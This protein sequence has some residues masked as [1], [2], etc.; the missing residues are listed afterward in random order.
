MNTEDIS[1]LTKVASFCKTIVMF[2][3]KVNKNIVVLPD[4][5]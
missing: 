2:F 5:M 3:D 1:L 4:I